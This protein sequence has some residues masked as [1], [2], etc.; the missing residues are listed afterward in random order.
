LIPTYYRYLDT[1]EGNNGRPPPLLFDLEWHSTERVNLVVLG[2]S[3]QRLRLPCY[4]P[5]APVKPSPEHVRLLAPLL[6]AHAAALART[7]TVPRR[8]KHR[9]DI[10]AACKAGGGVE[11]VRAHA[12]EL[13]TLSPNQDPRSQSMNS[14]WSCFRCRRI[15]AGSR[16]M[17][18]R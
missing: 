15:C 16:I 5:A 17:F 13:S 18:N 7:A 1:H 3:V 12:V 6:E 2:K 9:T 14:N 11:G 10:F 8:G 4:K